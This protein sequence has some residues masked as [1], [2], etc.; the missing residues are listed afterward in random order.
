[1]PPDS[2]RTTKTYPGFHVNCPT[3]CPFLT[4]AYF[5]SKFNK[6]PVPNFTKIL[7][8]G[9]ELIRGQRRTG[10]QAGVTKLQGTFHEYAN[11]H[12]SK[13]I[14]LCGTITAE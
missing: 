8:V 14:S 2:K 5:L 6:S 9:A 1:M 3:F 11:A 12:R 7:P 13:D 10:R 4:K